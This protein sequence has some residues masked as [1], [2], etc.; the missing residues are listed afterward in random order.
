MVIVVYELQPKVFGQ[1]AFLCLRLPNRGNSKHADLRTFTAQ[2][3][4]YILRFLFQKQV[5][6][7][8]D[9]LKITKF[10]DIFSPSENSTFYLKRLS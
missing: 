2:S 4:F 9:L 5:E 8:H 7:L 6:N 10:S 3:S 1:L